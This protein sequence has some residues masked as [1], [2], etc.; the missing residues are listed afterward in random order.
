MASR[1]E[2]SSVNEVIVFLR[3]LGVINVAVWLGTGVFFT[4]VVWPAFA[5]DAMLGIFARFGR[6][7]GEA[8]GTAAFLELLDRYFL[9]QAV[10]ASVALFHLAVEW[11]Y[12]GK[13]VRKST[14]GLIGGLLAMGALGYYVFQPKMKEN[15]VIRYNHANPAADREAA[16][17]AYAIVRGVT[18]VLNI[19]M[20]VGTGVY[21]WRV[22]RSN[23]TPRFSSP[24]RFNG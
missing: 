24:A 13:P 23:P 4:F 19:L 22:S 18:Q 9:V 14:L 1:G 8:Y 20:I 11:L 12:T 6:A 15:H 17:D 10:C 2:F 3:F 21:A 5:S 7:A 16:K